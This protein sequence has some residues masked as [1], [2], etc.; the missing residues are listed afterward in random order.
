MLSRPLN[1]A[2][3]EKST[4]LAEENSTRLAKYEARTLL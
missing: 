2:K 4:D 1:A 3:N